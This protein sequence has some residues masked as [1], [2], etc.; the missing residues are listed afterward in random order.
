MAGIAFGV[1]A[2][3]SLIFLPLAP[4]S[5]FAIIVWGLGLLG[6]SPILATI[7][8]WRLLGSLARAGQ[9]ARPMWFGALASAT[10]LLLAE[11]PGIANDVWLGWAVSS[12]PDTRARGIEL[13]RQWGDDEQLLS[14]AYIR[15]GPTRPGVWRFL[16]GRQMP[17]PDTGQAR[18]IYFR[19][20]GVAFNAVPRPPIRSLRRGFDADLGGGEVAGRSEFLRLESSRLDTSVDAAAASTEVSSRELS[21]CRNA[22]RPATSSPP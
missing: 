4:L 18:E 8:G 7:A 15:G 10:V 17:A 11:L 1:S 22:L 21:R 13:L 19:V 2:Y 6:L 9:P 16:V 20:T 12:D 14:A 3:Y 5:A